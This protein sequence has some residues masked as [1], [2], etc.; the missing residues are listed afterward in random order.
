M[1]PIV[2]V[3]LCL[4]VS[5][6]ILA[7]AAVLGDRLGLIDRPNEPR[8]IHTRPTPRIGGIT[9]GAALAVVTVLWIMLDG[10]LDRLL[11]SGGLFVMFHLVLGTLDD[12]RGLPASSRL[13][14]SIGAAMLLLASNHGL[15]IQSIRLGSGAAVALPFA[16]GFIL[17]TLGVVFFIF[18]VNLVDGRNGI[19]GASALW[20]L[21]MLQ[22]TSHVLADWAFAAL[23]GTLILFLRFNLKG[24]LFAGDGG[25]YVIG[26]GVAVLALSIYA[27][28]PATV[29]F[30]QLMIVFLLPLVDAMRVLISRIS[31][32]VTPF[33]ADDS[34][35]H[36]VLWRRAGEGWAM[37]IYIA[38]MIAPSV[39][40][41][42]CPAFATEIL[43]A[44]I[45][46]FFVAV[47]WSTATIGVH[48]PRVGRRPATGLDA[49]SRMTARLALAQ[50]RVPRRSR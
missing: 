1:V 9:F 22:L 43:V 28:R 47:G 40:A 25:A 26:S 8:K 7:H 50:S 12:R 2:A 45:G 13:L 6:S 35:F 11:A 15:V 10:R 17:T 24:R 41:L 23:A 5:W 18:S 46:I 27:R 34:H 38:L 39:G 14:A 16:A 32:S 48:A 44:A 33:R 29:A 37:A 42:A 19:L 49:A 20:W 21:A 31:R 4:I 36:Y 30:D 3:V